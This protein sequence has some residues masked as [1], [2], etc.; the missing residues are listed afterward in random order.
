MHQ[1]IEMNDKEKFELYM[2]LPKENLANMLIESNR[3]LS[4]LVKPSLVMDVN[5]NTY[6]CQH[7]YIQKDEYLKSCTH[8]GTLA[9]LKS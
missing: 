3:M 2:T 5:N 8:C 4:L 1:V 6:P 9:P 7:N